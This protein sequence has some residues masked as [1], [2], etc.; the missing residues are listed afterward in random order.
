[1]PVVPVLHKS[2]GF[3]KDGGESG[4][5]VIFN[6]VNTGGVY[7]WA[8]TLP[9][10]AGS[11]GE[12]CVRGVAGTKHKG[13]GRLAGNGPVSV[14]IRGVQTICSVHVVVRTV[15]G[16]VTLYTDHKV[17]LPEKSHSGVCSVS[18]RV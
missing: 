7:R 16:V 18:L 1:M 5:V 10:L 15:A 4:H 13:M 14:P 17:G 3:T 12:D 8:F 6:A 2:I 11:A 9:F